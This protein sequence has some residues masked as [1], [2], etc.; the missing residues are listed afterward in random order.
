MP[1]DP[2]MNFAVGAYKNANG[3]VRKAAF[4]LIMRIYSF[5]GDMTRSYFTTLRPPQ[6]KALEEGFNQMDGGETVVRK[7]D[8]RD[9]Y[10][11]E[12]QFG[13]FLIR[14]LS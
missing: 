13:N 1:I 11:N 4:D 8:K 7:N 14:Q 10:E 9:N 2:L 5:I 12:E 6:V 3:D